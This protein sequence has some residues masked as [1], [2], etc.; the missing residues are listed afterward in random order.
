MDKKTFN[1][2]KVDLINNKFQINQTNLFGL[3]LPKTQEK[4]LVNKELPIIIGNSKVGEDTLC[5]N[6]SSS[7]NCYSAHMGYCEHCNGRTNYSCY[8]RAL[9]DPF[10][11][12]LTQNL[13]CG[14][15]FDTL[16]IDELIQQVS[17]TIVKN[18]IKFIRYNSFGDFK[19]MEQ[20]LKANTLSEFCY[21]EFG[22]VSYTYTHNKDLEIDV[23]EKS[24]ITVNYSYKTGRD[25]V[26]HCITA[27]KWESKYLDDSKYVICNG[28]CYKCSY[29]KDKDDKRI[30]VFMAHGKGFKGS[31]MLPNGLMSVLNDIK[32][33]DW[34]KFNQRLVNP[35]K[36]KL[37]DFI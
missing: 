24:F 18:D 36:R 4:C 8:A 9:E 27:F 10:K 20:F 21:K 34:A 12:T 11:N 22:V 37:S 7:F 2:L 3:G 33:W 31:E 26:K 1:Q 35:S 30:I 23:L 17:E 13:L 29:C 6:M 16:S 15:L 25:N 14:Y 5:I 19:S 32:A 28:D